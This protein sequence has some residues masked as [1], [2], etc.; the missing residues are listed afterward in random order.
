MFERAT[1]AVLALAPGQAPCCA[2]PAT[3]WSHGRHGAAGL[4]SSA[5]NAHTTGAR[6]QTGVL[7]DAARR[8]WHIG[9]RPTRTR[10]SEIRDLHPI[11]APARCVCSPLAARILVSQLTA[12]G[13]ASLV[14]AVQ[15][16]RCRTTPRDESAF[17]PHELTLAY[18]WLHLLTHAFPG[19]IFD[20][21]ADTTS[22]ETFQHVY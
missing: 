16:R 22:L 19:C 6:R 14:S 4:L 8:R 2:M 7:E 20:I 5:R 1:D 21:S 10:A 12:R 11:A 9:A 15:P 3:C 13:A 17:P 18:T